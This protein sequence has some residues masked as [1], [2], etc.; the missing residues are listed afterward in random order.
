LIERLWWRLV[1]FG[2]RL[3]YNE[4]AFTYDLVSRFVSFG[5]WRCW[6]RASLKH[7]PPEKGAL[8]LELAHGTGSLQLDL[9]AAGYKVVGYDLSP[10][11]G[12]IA[13]G[14]LRR[15]GLTAWLA[16]GRAQQ[17]PF[18]AEA[19]AA[20]VSTFP[21]DFIAAEATLSEV[22]RVL[23]AEGVFVIVPNAQLVGGGVSEQ[24][25]EALY[26]IT[27]QRG[28]GVE[29]RQ[30]TLAVL[31][32]G[33]QVEVVQERCPRSVVTVIVARKDKEI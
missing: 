13:Q 28:D 19:F 30:D 27:G 26:R 24:S 20:V 3:L 4:F 29:T 12:R 21:T 15:Q 8:V 11:M 22:R 16:R 33:F 18:A 23:M 17:L 14:K 7:L 1:R 32:K 31:F 25:I 9:H 5:A 10:A 6:T 2:F